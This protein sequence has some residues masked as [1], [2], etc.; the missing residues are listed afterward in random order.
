MGAVLWAL[1]RL[2]LFGALGNLPGDL[3][4]RRGPVTVVMPFTTMLLVST[5]LTVVVNLLLRFF[6]R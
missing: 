4:W 2:P 1:A 5:A 3:A 6:R